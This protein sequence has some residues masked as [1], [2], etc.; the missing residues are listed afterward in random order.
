[1]H[2]QPAAED[3]TIERHDDLNVPMIAL[4]GVLACVLTFALVL[5]V[6]VLYYRV[7]NSEVQRKVIAAQAMD[8]ASIMAEQEAKLARYGW[9]DR[10]QGRATIPIERAMELIV[11]ERGGNVAHD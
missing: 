6:Q 1:M 10:A 9:L 4:F 7:A 2:S 3:K 8:S 11:Q 5:G